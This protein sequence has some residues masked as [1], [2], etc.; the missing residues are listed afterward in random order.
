MTPGQV[1]KIGNW[2]VGKC[3]DGEDGGWKVLIGEEV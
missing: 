1:L 3:E 2:V